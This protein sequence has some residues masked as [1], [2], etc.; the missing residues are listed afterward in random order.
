MRDATVF[1]INGWVYLLNGVWGL[2]FILIGLLI[3][4]FILW[5]FGPLLN[6][7]SSRRPSRYGRQPL[8]ADRGDIWR[9]ALPML[10]WAVGVSFAPTEIERLWS[11]LL[12]AAFAFALA[13]I[14]AERA[15]VMF[16]HSWMLAFYGV[17]AAG[18]GFVMGGGLSL[19][20]VGGAL[21]L[22][23][24]SGLVLSSVRSSIV[25]W[26]GFILWGLYP[27]GFLTIIVQRL[28]VSRQSHG[29][30]PEDIMSALSARGEHIQR[31]VQRPIRPE[32]DNW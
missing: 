23:S 28:Q 12:W 30:A 20:Q 5:R 11:I 7:T 3:G 32:K 25:P 9:Q 21:H 14:P 8:R 1:W 16:R 26:A 2:K 4:C 24:E 15:N 29:G 10:I 31:K 6:R 19:A 27:I 17:G 18:F 22:S 13:A